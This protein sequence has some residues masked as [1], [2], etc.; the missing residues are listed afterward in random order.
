MGFIG[1]TGVNFSCRP[2]AL[3][4]AVRNLI[5]NANKYG[6]GAS[7]SLRTGPEYLDIS[8]SD[9]GPGIPAD[10]IDLALEPF[11]R[12]SMARES[13]QGGFGLG[14]AIVEAIAKGHH[15]ELIL[16]NNDPSGLVATIRL[17]RMISRLTP[18]N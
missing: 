17:P 1:E 12:L 6:G 5:E 4:R 13:Q 2:D 7:V 3:A 8:V 9:A 15:G 14:L 11:R 18:A 16:A 10:K